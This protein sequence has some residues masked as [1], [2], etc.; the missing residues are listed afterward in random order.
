MTI[1]EVYAKNIMPGQIA[2]HIKCNPADTQ[3]IETERQ[4]FKKWLDGRRGSYENQIW[5]WNAYCYQNPVYTIDTKTEDVN[6]MY[7]MTYWFTLWH[8]YNRKYDYLWVRS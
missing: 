6:E 3:A 4:K 5:A 2:R 1:N 7:F 8:P